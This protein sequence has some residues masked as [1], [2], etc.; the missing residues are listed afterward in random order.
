MTKWSALSC[1]C[2]AK[3]RAACRL[4]L[5]SAAC[6]SRQRGSGVCPLG[7]GSGAVGGGG[8]AAPPDD[9]VGGGGGGGGGGGDPPVV[10]GR[11][12]GSGVALAVGIVRDGDALSSCMCDGATT[13]PRF[14]ASLASLAACTALCSVASRL[15]G[16]GSFSSAD[17]ASRSRRSPTSSSVLTHFTNA[18]H[19]PSSAAPLG[20]Q[21][22]SST[23]PPTLSCWRNASVAAASERISSGSSVRHPAALLLT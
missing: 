19:A 2:R 13:I 7:D 1:G 12:E 11:G 20:H 8:A 10:A 6:F 17:A 23:S 16:S 9:T 14:A 5:V 3:S 21:V 22:E 18:V 15:P 4:H